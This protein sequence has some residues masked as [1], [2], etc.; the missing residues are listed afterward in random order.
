[1]IQELDKVEIDPK[2]FEKLLSLKI[3]P[4]IFRVINLT[5]IGIFLEILKKY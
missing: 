1:M 2:I 4:L 3:H 5:F